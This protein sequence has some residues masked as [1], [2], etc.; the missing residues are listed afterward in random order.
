[1]ADPAVLEPMICDA[2]SRRLLMMFAYAD[3][4]R[5]VEPHLYRRRPNAAR[6]LCPFTGCASNSLNA[7][8]TSSRAEK[9]L[10]TPHLA[11]RV[12]R[13]RHREWTSAAS[14]PSFS[15]ISRESY[16]CAFP[17]H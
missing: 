16:Q 2:I 17:K 4:V 6:H 14:R 15:T 10:Y 8:N 1:M 7:V 5:V 11:V 9:R 12:R 13:L 3:T